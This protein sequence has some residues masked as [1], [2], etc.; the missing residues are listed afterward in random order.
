M[1]FFSF[2]HFLWKV[3]LTFRLM[4][5][6]YSLNKAIFMHKE[7]TKRTLLNSSDK[8]LT[9]GHRDKITAVLSDIS[10]CSMIN[11]F[12]SFRSTHENWIVIIL[13]WNSMWSAKKMK[14]RKK[15]K[16][17]STNTKSLMEI[18]R[19]IN[20]STQYY[21]TVN[22]TSITLRNWSWINKTSTVSAL[23]CITACDEITQKGA[24]CNCV[25]N[26]FLMNL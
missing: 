19:C 8:H 2:I 16:W 18:R 11:D 21:T 25:F 26:I 14:M 7:Q 6:C 1:I 4:A 15:K 13:S 10:M 9:T 23:L 22:K 17:D 5:F 24:Y 20:T 3:T 12:K